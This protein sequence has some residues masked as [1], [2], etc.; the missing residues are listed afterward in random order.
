MSSWILKINLD[1]RNGAS[2]TFSLFSLL[3][4]GVSG[5]YLSW[6]GFFSLL[7]SLLNN[8]W[9][10]LISFF[11][12]SDSTVAPSLPYPFGQ[13]VE[14]LSLSALPWQMSFEPFFDLVCNHFPLLSVL[15]FAFSFIGILLVRPLFR[16]CS[17]VPARQGS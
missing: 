4:E 14:P 12:V 11:P 5:E 7:V 2:Q 8:S 1:Q 10:S 16:S 6:P 9:L 15:I 17:P 3:V 13:E